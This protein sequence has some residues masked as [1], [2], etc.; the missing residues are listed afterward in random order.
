M[1]DRRAHFLTMTGDTCAAAGLANLVVEIMLANGTVR[2]GVPSP[3]SS[4]DEDSALDETGYSN[5]LLVDGGLIRLEDVV[6]FAV[7]SP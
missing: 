7:H 5:L 4:E 2:S 1:N 6:G 3:R